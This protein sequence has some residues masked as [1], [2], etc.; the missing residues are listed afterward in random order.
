MVETDASNLVIAGMLSQYDN[1][2]ILPSVA[3]FSQKYSPA[4]INYKIYDKEPLAIV[5][6]FK[7]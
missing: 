4:E 3:Y 2:D 6:A 5:H 7:E 1:N